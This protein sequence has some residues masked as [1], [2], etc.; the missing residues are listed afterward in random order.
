MAKNIP[1]YLIH[2][3]S[4]FAD[5]ET[6][7]G[8]VE[9]IS[10]PP[11]EFDTETFLNGGMVKKREVLMGTMAELVLNFKETAFDGDMLSLIGLNDKEYM[12]VGEMHDAD[13]GGKQDAVIYY[14]GTM[15]KFDGGSWK[16]GE[17]A[18]S[19]YD[20]ACAY[21]KLTIGDRT[22]YEGTDYWFKVD[23]EVVLG[24]PDSMIHG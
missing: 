8:Q 9:E 22:V 17:K 16:P 23:G 2:N 11:I 1:Q 14:R 13:G 6:R 7:I 5:K 20:I 12:A 21:I 19:D 24:N 18:M 4:L 10:T 3:C 15:K